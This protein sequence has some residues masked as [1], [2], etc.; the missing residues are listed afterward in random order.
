MLFL[1]KRNVPRSLAALVALVALGLGLR[2]LVT[3]PTPLEF[4]PTQALLGLEVVGLVLVGD[5]LIH[6]LSL[7]LFGP[8]Y[9]A[10]YQQLAGTF[11]Q[12]PLAAMVSGALMAGIGEELVFRGLSASPVVLMPLAVAF[13]LLHHLGRTLWPFTLWSI[14]EGLLFAFAVVYTQAL[15]PTMIAHFL[16]DLIGFLI[17]RWVNRSS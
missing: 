10:L 3:H 6:G 17:F 11:R 15:L 9:W 2:L 13:G 4:T 5:A 8:R 12:Q 1:L 16:H 14:W 7:L